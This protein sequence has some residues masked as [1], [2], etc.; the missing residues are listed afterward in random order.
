MV[1]SFLCAALRRTPR[2]FA[3][4]NSGARIPAQTKKKIEQNVQSFS[5]LGLRDGNITFSDELDFDPE[6]LD[7][8]YEDN[9]TEVS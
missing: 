1:L 7:M 5:W 6:E 2:C 3:T 4:Q 8:V 9:D